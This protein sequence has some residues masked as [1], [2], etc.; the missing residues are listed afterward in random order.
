MRPAGTGRDVFVNYTGTILQVSINNSFHTIHA[1]A[2]FGPESTE[3]SHS[4]AS[5]QLR[6]PFGLKFWRQSHHGRINEIDGRVHHGR[7]NHD[8]AH[9]AEGLVHP[10]VSP[11]ERLSF[12]LYNKNSQL[13]IFKTHFKPILSLIAGVA[14]N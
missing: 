2:R 7:A 14:L 12:F 4:H 11:I 5:P 3:G 9:H 13:N 10:F 8:R 6:I 1:P